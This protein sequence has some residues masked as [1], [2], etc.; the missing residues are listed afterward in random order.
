MKWSCEYFY[1][2]SYDKALDF[3]RQ[4]WECVQEERS[5]V[6]IGAGTHRERV[7]TIG[8]QGC[9]EQLVKDG[10]FIVRNIDRGGGATAHEPGQLVLYPILH[11]EELRLSVPDLIWVFETSMIDF[12]AELGLHGQRHVSG[13][14]IF[15]GD[16]KIGFIGLRIKEKIVQHGLALNLFNDA[17]IFKRFAPCGITNLAVTSACHLAPLP[18]ALEHYLCRL[19]YLFVGR[20]HERTMMGINLDVGVL[21][22]NATESS[23]TNAFASGK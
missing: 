15:I 1:E 19:V 11:I 16:E 17:Q 8:R 13:P 6:L 4:A 21:L 20:L 5:R 14:G 3:M 18:F 12:L 10:S 23:G 22:S 7:V 2:W 9:S